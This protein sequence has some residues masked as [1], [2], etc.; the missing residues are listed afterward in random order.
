MARALKATATGSP[1]VVYSRDGSDK[2]SMVDAL[3]AEGK[4]AVPAV[5]I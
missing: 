4:A 5:D 1:R 2:S 3:V